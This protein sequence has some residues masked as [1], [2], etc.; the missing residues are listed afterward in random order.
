[1]VVQKQKWSSTWN[2]NT[3]KEVCPQRVPISIDI[4][5][6]RGYGWNR[7]P[8]IKD[9]VIVIGDYRND[10]RKRLTPARPDRLEL[11]LKEVV[12]IYHEKVNAEIARKQRE[13]NAN[14]A[15]KDRL[16]TIGF[17]NIHADLSGGYSTF[18][19]GNEE[20]NVSLSTSRYGVDGLR[21]KASDDVYAKILTYLQEQELEN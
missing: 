19:I 20:V 2:L 5:H 8:A 6:K 3:R 13:V 12:E 10:T 11:L 7:D 9:I 21:I 1:M 4:H 17:D 14:L 16:M 18:K 15:K